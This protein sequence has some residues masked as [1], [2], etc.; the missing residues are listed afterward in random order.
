MGIDYNRDKAYQPA[1]FLELMKA[2]VRTGTARLESSFVQLLFNGELTM[3]QVRGWARQDY[4]LKK[5]PTWWVAARMLNSPSMAVQRRL[6]G[7]LNEELGTE[8]LSHTD[9]YLQFGRALGYTDEEMEEAPLLPSTVL[10]V[11]ELM[12]INRN[13]SVMESLASGSVAEGA[14]GFPSSRLAV[15]VGQAR[16]AERRTPQ[17]A[18]VVAQR[19]VDELKAARLFVADEPFGQMSPQD[20]FIDS[21]RR[22]DNGVDA[23]PEV[24]VGKAHNGA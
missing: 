6:M 14:R 24:F 19:G 10:A 21:A 8:A 2:E 15:S 16:F 18:G 22:V 1:E 3:D 12:S 5:C 17:L 23:L 9:M 11:D 7:T 20:V 4:A 13:R